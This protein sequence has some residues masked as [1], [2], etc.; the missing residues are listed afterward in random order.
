MKCGRETEREGERESAR[1]RERASEREK[2][3]LFVV[4]IV[5]VVET[6]LPT[7]RDSTHHAAGKIRLG[8]KGAGGEGRGRVGDTQAEPAAG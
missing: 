6:G 8:Q 4:V 7:S 3:Y 5:N 1:A 2:K